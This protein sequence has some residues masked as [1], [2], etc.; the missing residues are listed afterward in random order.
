LIA[1]YAYC[2]SKLLQYS[3]SS[4]V[5]TCYASVGY[6]GVGQT[7][8][9]QAAWKLSLSAHWSA[10]ADKRWRPFDRLFYE[11]TSPLR[12]DYNSNVHTVRRRSL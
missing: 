2:S 12:H 8:Q 11:W 3:Q 4:A 5:T 9:S 6:G 1:I 10:A 7:G